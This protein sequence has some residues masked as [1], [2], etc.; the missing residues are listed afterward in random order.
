VTEAPGRAQP[1]ATF[2]L[3]GFSPAVEEVSV[4]LPASLGP[5]PPGGGGTL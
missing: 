3:P 2:G 1:G 4:D 5:G